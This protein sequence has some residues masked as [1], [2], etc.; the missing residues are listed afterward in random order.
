MART[1]ALASRLAGTPIS[2]DRAW[3]AISECPQTGSWHSVAVEA[4]HSLGLHTQ[5]LHQLPTHLSTSQPTLGFTADGHW[6]LVTKRRGRLLRATEVHTHGQS[7]RWWTPAQ[8]QAAVPDTTWVHI[9]PLYPLSAISSRHRPHLTDHP[10]RRLLGFLSLEHADLWVIAVYAVVIG[11]LTLGTPIAVQ[12]LVN[13]VAFGSVVQ[14]LV[15]LSVML[16]LVLSFAGVLGV[17][18]AYVIEVLQR[19]IFVRIAGDFGRRL[20]TVCHEAFDDIHG[21]ERVNR[22]F[23]VLTIQKTLSVLLLDGLTLT[24]QAMLGM[25]LLGLYHPLL[26]TFDILLLGLLIAVLLLGRGAVAA[27]VDE[28]TAKYQTAAWLQDVSRASQLFRNTA[29]RR[30][31]AVR[32]ELLCHNYLAARKKHFRILLRQIGG[33]MGLQVIATVSLLGVGGYLVIDRQLT[34]GQLVA[35][36]LVIATIGASFVKLGKNLEK[37]YDLDVAIL[38]VSKVVDLPTERIGGT[39]FQ[40]TGP[41]SVCVRELSV[42]RGGAALSSISMQIQAGERVL[43]SGPAGSGKHTL[44]EVIAGLRT[45]TSGTI[46]IDGLDTRRVDLAQL[47]SAVIM[48]TQKRFF[49][50]TVIDN[51]RLGHPEIDERTIRQLLIAVDIEQA[52]DRLPK[53]LDTRLLPDGAPLSTTQARRLAL[54]RTLAMRPRLLLIDRTLDRLGLADDVLERLLDTVLGPQAPWTVIVV[55][56]C[57]RVRARCSRHLRI[58]GPSVEEVG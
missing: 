32:T 46:V 31:A 50:G 41:A 35:A 56:D 30:Y 27:G 44:L 29:A 6:L 38:K 9:H 45:Q 42:R 12:S 21:P 28:S 40:G 53:G 2:D 11:S 4:A 17:F 39:P 43:L 23:D 10:W 25:I 48:A 37:I 49:D 13:T 58:T 18:E 24:L 57:P 26:L 22:F 20:P 34:L 55:S 19:R 1:L 47:R 7:R 51:I 14:P 36:E 3:L 33:G 54:A 8:L 16:L 15:V 5:V 52:I